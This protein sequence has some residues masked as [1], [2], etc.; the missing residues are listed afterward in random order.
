VNPP[1]SIRWSVVLIILSLVPSIIGFIVY[2]ILPGRLDGAFALALVTDV[3][4]VGFWSW[5]ARKTWQG[6]TWAR[7]VQMVLLPLGIAALVITSIRNHT[8]VDP[9]PFIVSAAALALLWTS[10]SRR[11]FAETT[12]ALHPPQPVKPYLDPKNR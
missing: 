3:V 11:Y 2:R 9:L 4:I 12:A 7:T 6:R 10:A 5:I 8:T 1:P